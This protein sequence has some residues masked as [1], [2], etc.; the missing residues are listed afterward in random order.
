MFFFLFFSVRGKRGEEERGKKKVNGN[1]NLDNYKMATI[2]ELGIGSIRLYGT[3]NMTNLF[4]KNY[5][6][7]DL[8]PFAI[9]VRFSK[10]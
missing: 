9:G 6:K 10:F 3:Y 8:L 4:D 5:T 1:F 2:G 7:L